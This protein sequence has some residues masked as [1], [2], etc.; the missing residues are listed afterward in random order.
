APFNELLPVT[1]PDRK[2]T[3]HRDPAYP[4]LTPAGHD[5]LLT[6]IEEDPE[7]NAQRWKTLPY[8][9]NYQEIGA[10]KPGATLL[11]QMD[12]DGRGTLPLLA[13]ENYGRG[14]TAVFAT[15]GSWR[16]QML[17]PLEDMSHET[18]WR[19]L[20]RWLVTDTPSRVTASTP[21]SVLYD[22]GGVKLRAEVRDTTYLPAGDAQV[23]ARMIEPDGH[24]ETVELRPDATD[25][26]VY[27]GDW[28]APRSGSYVAEISARRGADELGKDV[29]TF[30]RE[31]GA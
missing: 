21:R 31:D 26:G 30:R 4:S 13:T 23:S 27:T 2:G 16:W 19:Q 24:E 18:F 14:R 29:V 3:F 1:L 20:L 15:A 6:R 25:V 11:A 28:N 17:Q 12:V 9:A 5:S 10:T 7:R 8:L 22:E